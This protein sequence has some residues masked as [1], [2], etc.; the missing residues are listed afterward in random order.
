M[1]LMPLPKTYDTTTFINAEVDTSDILPRLALEYIKSLPRHKDL[2]AYISPTST[3]SLIIDVMYEK[4]GFRSMI[5]HDGVHIADRL[6]V[7]TG[8]VLRKFKNKPIEAIDEQL[9]MSKHRPHSSKRP[10]EQEVVV[11][12]ISHNNP[13]AIRMYGEFYTNVIWIL[14]ERKLKRRFWRIIEQSISVF[15]RFTK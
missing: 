13:D 5:D 15:L 10:K 8:V 9:G 3:D 4:Y 12:S 6:G 2:R 11:H 1:K 14:D 7:F